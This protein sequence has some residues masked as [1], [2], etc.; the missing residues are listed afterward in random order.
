MRNGGGSG[1]VDMLFLLNKEV[2]ERYYS[3]DYLMH[4][5]THL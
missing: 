3:L 5:E 4:C 2:N 1:P